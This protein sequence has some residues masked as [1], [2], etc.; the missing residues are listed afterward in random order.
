MQ[1]VFSD[2]YSIA[3]TASEKRDQKSLSF[4]CRPNA[5]IATE[6]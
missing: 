2:T 3:K 6:Y 1:M 4:A 5:T